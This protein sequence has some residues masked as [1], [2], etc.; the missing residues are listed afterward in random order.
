[1][2]VV[3]KDHV[4]IIQATISIWH[5]VSMTGL[6]WLAALG[7]KTV[8]Y[9]FLS[10]LLTKSVSIPL[11]VEVPSDLKYPDVV[12]YPTIVPTLS[13]LS[14]SLPP[15]NKKKNQNSIKQGA[16]KTKGNKMRAGTTTAGSSTAVNASAG[17][18]TVKNLRRNPTRRARANP[19]QHV[20]SV[21]SVLEAPSECEPRSLRE[22]ASG[23]G[24]DCAQVELHNPSEI[25]EDEG[26]GQESEKGK[27]L[28][29]SQITLEADR[30]LGT[31]PVKFLG[32]YHVLLDPMY[33]D[34]IS[35]GSQQP[36]LKRPYGQ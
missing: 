8:E 3:T 1:M 34:G 2:W 33:A 18:S 5:S 19:T 12:Q 29:E 30:S 11:P 20:A 21:R 23:T 36:T 26:Q 35:R 14:L 28:G 31:C 13:E 4:V 15:V 9:I 22:G 16:G 10:P 17:S 6:K 27:D 25:E 7:V 24:K 32:V